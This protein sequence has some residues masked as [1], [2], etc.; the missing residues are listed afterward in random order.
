MK[1]RT[2]WAWKIYFLFYT[3]IILF[4]ILILLSG[5]SPISQYYCVL[6]AF[7]Q[8]YS[9]QYYLYISKIIVEGVS[10]IPLFLF[11]IHRRAIPVTIW[12]ILF[13]ARIFFL[14]AGQSYEW[15]VFKAMMHG[16]S[17]TTIAALFL[18]V[19]FAIPSYIACFK[20]AFRQKQLFAE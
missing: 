20:Y 1:K 18:A 6:I 10:L 15:N 7:K 2:L 4:N 16:N 3:L 17:T 13:G 14:F 5:E 19:L 9:I 12:Q 11:V 8:S